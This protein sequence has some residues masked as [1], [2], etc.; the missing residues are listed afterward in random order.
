MPIISI[1]TLSS[2][3]KDMSFV[4]EPDAKTSKIVTDIIKKV[5][6]EGDKSIFELAQKLDN[7]SLASVVVPK[8]IVLESEERLSPST[9]KVL[10]GA[11]QNIKAFHENQK[12]KDWE[13][14]Y[15]DKTRLG[16]K[17]TPL[18]RVGIYVP[19]GKA[20]YPSTMIMNAIPAIIAEVPS[21]VVASTPAKNGL[22]HYL[23]LAICSMLGIHEILVSGG[24]QAIAA[25]AYGTESIEPVCKITG[26][27]NRFV[28][29]AKKQ[30]FGKVGIDSLAGPSEIIILHDDPT[31]PDEFLV[32]D[33]L[34][35]AEHDE[36]ARAILI[37]N[38][39]Q[40]AERVQARIEE[41]VPT[42]PRTD[43]I[44]KSLAENGMIIVVDKIQEGIDL[45]NSLAPEH[46]ELMVTEP[47]V[48]NKINN[49][50]AIF[51]GRWSS[52]TIGDYYAGPNHTI[53][54]SGTAKFGSPLSVRDFQKHSSLIEYS[55][56]RLMKE[57]DQIADFAEM[58]GLHAHAE[59]VKVRK[60]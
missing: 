35:Q 13:V 10:E 59:A 60:P 43:I 28:A 12:Q 58:E 4:A 52:E 39:K 3:N 36:D 22:P 41:L 33:L 26:P 44:S 56:E 37:T 29:E 27:G 53:P 47:D 19:G 2:F 17:V 16:E 46:L 31:I 1:E 9:R 18:D 55:E 23:V 24:A 32:R 20:F 57:L 45:V 51:I 25:M 34:T 42:L 6:D 8:E 54:T 5:R 21:I 49:A 30:V 40:T 50:G 14:V 38:S 11:I 7:V 48:I 15:P